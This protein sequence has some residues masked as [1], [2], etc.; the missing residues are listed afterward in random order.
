MTHMTHAID[1][2]RASKALLGT[3]PYLLLLT[4]RTYLLASLRCLK[5][6]PVLDGNMSQLQKATEPLIHTLS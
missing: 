1:L 6:Q 3:S 4:S 2:P 5:T